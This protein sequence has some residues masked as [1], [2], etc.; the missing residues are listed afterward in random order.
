MMTFKPSTAEDIGCAYGDA[1][2]EETDYTEL[3]EK[4]GPL[5]SSFIMGKDPRV[6]AG[7]ACAKA[8][9]FRQ[10]E[11]NAKIGLMRNVYSMQAEKFE[12]QC[13]GYQELAD[14]ERGA[15]RNT[16]LAKFAVIGVS[17]SAIFLLWSAGST[18]A[19]VK[20]T[21]RWKREGNIR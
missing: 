21:E 9:N 1:V 16:Q 19:E 14:E 6:E 20:Q 18:L 4:Y 17:L 2:D 7:T 10:L 15:Q 12:G 11:A 5:V 8:K 13:K 3:L